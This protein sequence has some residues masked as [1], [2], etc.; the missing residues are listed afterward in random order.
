MM[1]D[2]SEGTESR[3]KRPGLLAAGRAGRFQ[4]RGLGGRRAVGGALRQA[5]D[6]MISRMYGRIV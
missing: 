4:R 5:G 1:G 3:K 6:G 2:G